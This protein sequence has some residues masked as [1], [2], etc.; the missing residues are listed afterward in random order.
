MS[1]SKPEAKS[2]FHAIAQRA[3]IRKTARG[4][5]QTRLLFAITDLEWIAW[6]L[7]SEDAKAFARED[8]EDWLNNRQDD[9]SVI[10]FGHRMQTLKFRSRN[11]MRVDRFSRGDWDPGLANPGP[12][13]RA[14]LESRHSG[15]LLVMN[16]AI[17]L[18]RQTE[19]FQ[20]VLHAKNRIELP[21]RIESGTVMR[22]DVE[23]YS[24]GRLNNS[25]RFRKRALR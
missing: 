13:P 10:V 15:E 3:Y 22:G 23:R 7:F 12:S 6:Y 8:V 21:R 5:S 17:Y 18:P 19:R 11:P 16:M 25:K 2:Y 14:I 9:Q 24:A 20:M 1:R 4:M